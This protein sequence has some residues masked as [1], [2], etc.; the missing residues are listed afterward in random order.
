[1][2]RE[3]ARPIP[4]GGGLVCRVSGGSEISG[5]GG[6]GE[7][8]EEKEIYRRRLLRLLG[9][10]SGLCGWMLGW[11]WFARALRFVDAVVGGS[12]LSLAL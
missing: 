12:G 11:T 2:P 9:L 8:R 3:R 4:G 10:E 5:E 1:M 7:E 6:K